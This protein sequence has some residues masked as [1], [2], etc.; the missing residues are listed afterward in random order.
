MKEK[1][2]I[3]DDKGV[4][5]SFLPK[6]LFYEFLALVIL[7]A[8]LA[9]ECEEVIGVCGLV[10]VSG[11]VLVMVLAG[12]FF[13]MK[14]ILNKKFVWKKVV[15]GVF[16]LTFLFWVVSDRRNIRVLAGNDD[17]VELN[18]N[19]LFVVLLIGLLKK[20]SE[21]NNKILNLTI[22]LLTGFYFCYSLFVSVP[23]NPVILIVYMVAV[24]LAT[25]IF[26]SK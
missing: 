1:G 2:K 5:N 17:E 22:F 4:D 25:F 20:Y 18:Y 15:F 9:G 14:K 11:N 24:L 21:I 19:A 23:K 26:S 3:G 13:V 16:V 8:F 12:A 6:R 7:N 10:V